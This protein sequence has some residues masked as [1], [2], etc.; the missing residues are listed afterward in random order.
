MTARFERTAVRPEM[1]PLPLPVAGEPGLVL[2]DTTWGS[3]QP[4]VV[5]EGVRTVGESELVEHLENGMPA[6]DSRDR[7]AYE[8]ATIPSAASLPFADAVV[9][10]DELD[11]ER[12]TVFFCNG[13]QCGQSPRAIRALVAAGH[14]PELIWYYR[15]GLHDWVTLGL[16]VVSAA[17]S[18]D[19]AGSALPG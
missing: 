13:P 8:A 17:L 14:P 12:P 2:V 9:R 11:R 1:Q 10:R 3:I 18:A 6:V 4:M 7:D 5:A 16:P 15:G 19:P